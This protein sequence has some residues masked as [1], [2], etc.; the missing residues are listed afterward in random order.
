MRDEANAKLNAQRERKGKPLLLSYAKV[1]IKVDTGISDIGKEIQHSGP[2]ALYHVCSHLR[3]RSGRSGLVRPHMR[4]S[5]TACVC[6]QGHVVRSVD[7]EV[8][9]WR[10]EPL[11]APEILKVGDAENGTSKFGDCVTCPQ[12]RIVRLNIDERDN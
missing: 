2:V 9:E 8:G 6:K 7:Y 11:H 4:G 10:G 5:P 3:F 12:E 1:G